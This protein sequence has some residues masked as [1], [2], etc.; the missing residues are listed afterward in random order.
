M[1]LKLRDKVAVVTGAASGIGA[2][3]AVSFCTEGVKTVFTD[4]NREGLEKITKICG[5][6][7]FPIQC[8]VAN[9]DS[10]KHLFRSIRDQ[11]KQLHILV[12]NAAINTADYVTDLKDEDIQ[13]VLS[14]NIRGYIYT[15]EEAVQLMKETGS[16]RL[17]FINSGSGLKASAGMSLYSGSKYFNRGFAIST[18]LEVGKFNITANSICPSDVYP[19]AGHDSG[20]ENNHEDSRKSIF[21]E[22]TPRSWTNESLIR[23]S[24]EKEG[25]VSLE[26]LIRKR[27]AKNP[28]N[29]SCTPEDIANLALF[30]ASEKA[31]FIN[32]QSIGVNGGALPY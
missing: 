20:A 8:D 19:A 32:G 2:Y 25:V 17:I 12:N 1:D 26:E 29:R 30:L 28:M 10:V 5:D 27:T 21:R 18:A 24:L 7:A 31:G 3:I 16:G 6:N 13:R 22:I 9:R 4:I 23:I 14:I 15:T 11:F